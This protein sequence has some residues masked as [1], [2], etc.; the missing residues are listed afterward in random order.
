[1]GEGEQESGEWGREGR[2]RA[3]PGGT[4]RGGMEEASSPHGALSL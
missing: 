1:M 3:R 4:G 2:W